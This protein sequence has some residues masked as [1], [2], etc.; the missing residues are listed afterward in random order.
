MNNEI[1]R[2]NRLSE[3]LRIAKKYSRKQAFQEEL[4]AYLDDKLAKYNVPTHEIMEIVQ[5][6]MIGNDF[7]V[8]DEVER[9]Y[10]FWN[11]QAKRGIRRNRGED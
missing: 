5:Y 6:M 11:S 9:A 8:R 7:V 4:L 1:E 3:K 10:R 2:K